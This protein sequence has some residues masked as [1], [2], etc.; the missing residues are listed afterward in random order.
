MNLYGLGLRRE[1]AVGWIGECVLHGGAL[2]GPRKHEGK[3]G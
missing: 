1:S 3:R 2:S